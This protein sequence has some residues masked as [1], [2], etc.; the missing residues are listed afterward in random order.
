VF[1]DEK[2]RRRVPIGFADKKNAQAKRPF[3]VRDRIIS[4]AL[5]D[6]RPENQTRRPT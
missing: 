4:H 6:G 2:R 3:V 1:D 5:F